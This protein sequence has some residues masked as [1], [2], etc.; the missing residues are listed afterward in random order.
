M[1]SNTTDDKQVNT[2]TAYDDICRDLRVLAARLELVA[3][4]LPEPLYPGIP[5]RLS[6]G[7][8]SRADVL[9]TANVMGIVMED[10]EPWQVAA[11]MRVGTVQVEWYWHDTAMC[12]EAAANDAAPVSA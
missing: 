2:N 5:Q 8:P 4:V 6:I 11:S 7:L 12:A 3:T 9:H 1:T 10:R